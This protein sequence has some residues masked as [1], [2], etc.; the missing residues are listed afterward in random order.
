MVCFPSYPK[1]SVDDES[2]EPL[3][4]PDRKIPLEPIEIPSTLDSISAFNFAPEPTPERV[5]KILIKLSQGPAPRVQER[6]S[7][8]AMPST[9]LPFY[10]HS[11]PQGASVVGSGAY[12]HPIFGYT[13]GY[14]FDLSK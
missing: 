9:V 8:V 14:S 11:K 1:F 10:K 5:E 2:Q 7:M 4:C 12:V 3:I 13:L 6:L